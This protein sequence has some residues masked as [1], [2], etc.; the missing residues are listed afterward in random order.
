MGVG[1]VAMDEEQVGL[2]DDAG[3]QD[4]VHRPGNDNTPMSAPVGEFELENK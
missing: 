4:D 1:T 2:E 3:L